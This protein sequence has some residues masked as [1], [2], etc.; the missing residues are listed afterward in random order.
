MKLLLSAGKLKV[1]VKVSK[2][3]VPEANA[4]RV[5][6]ITLVSVLRYVYMVFVFI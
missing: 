1:N 3:E 5:K 4:R 6:V 2:K